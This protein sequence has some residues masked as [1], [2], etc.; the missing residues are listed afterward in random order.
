MESFADRQTYSDDGYAIARGLFS[1][2]E[3]ELYKAH[4]MELHSQEKGFFTREQNAAA[5]SDPLK[6]YPRMVHMHRWDDISLDWMLQERLKR[7][8]TELLG[9]EPYAVQTMFY[10]KPPGARGQAL[11]QDQAPLNV[12]PGTCMA[13]WMALDPCTEENGCLQIVPGTHEIDL[14]CTVD[15]D[16]DES[17]SDKMVPLPEDVEPRSILMEPG[18]VLFF[19]GQV[20]HGSY[21]NRTPDRFRRALIGHYIVGEAEKVGQFYH[22]VLRFDGSEVVLGV[23][24]GGQPCGEWATEDGSLVINQ[25]PDE[26]ARDMSM[27]AVVDNPMASVRV[28]MGDKQ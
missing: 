6:K 19:N 3:V 18:D 24:A 25:R 21:A 16:T 26:R 17:F 8:M 7:C 13:A 27:A 14:L 23:S 11:H 15:A 1:A 28:Q 10:F 12:Q 22:P 2:D 5:D 9:A 20:I 4:F